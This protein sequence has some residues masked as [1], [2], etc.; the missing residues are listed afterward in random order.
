MKTGVVV[1]VAAALVAGVGLGMHP[2]L[3]RRVAPGFAGAPSAA[4]TGADLAGAG[5]HK[6]RTASGILYA[7]HA[8]PPGSHEVAAN[9]GTVSVVPFPKAA[10]EAA[11]SGPRIIRATSA[12]EVER[13]RDR[14]ID[15]ASNR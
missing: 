1:A 3:V 8:C 7:D 9:G 15:Q 14:M 13:M 11:A 6:C 12:D 5:V 4:P 2:E 10:A